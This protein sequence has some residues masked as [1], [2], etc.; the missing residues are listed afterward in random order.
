MKCLQCGAYETRINGKACNDPSRLFGDRL[1]HFLGV[2][3]VLTNK[4]LVER[5]LTRDFREGC[6]GF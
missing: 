3:Q 1:M 2:E 4:T 5:T 6:P